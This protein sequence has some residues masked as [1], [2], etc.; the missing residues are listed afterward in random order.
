M[1]Y[2]K[3]AGKLDYLDFTTRIHRLKKDNE[4]EE[5]K[6]IIQKFKHYRLKF[7]VFQNEIFFIIDYSRQKHIL[8]T[9]NVEEIIGYH[10]SEFL[11]NGLAMVIDIFQKAQNLHSVGFEK[12]WKW[13]LNNPFQVN[14]DCVIHTG[15]G[16]GQN[17]SDEIDSLI[18]Y[19]LLK[20]KLVAVHGVA[21]NSEQAAH[22]KG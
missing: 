11:E 20:R 5:L 13:K 8:L 9:G 6:L 21:M 14:R 7:P 17:S 10:P 3:T 19:N 18:K 15:E 22:F 1:H 4:A 16:T 2:M 12:N